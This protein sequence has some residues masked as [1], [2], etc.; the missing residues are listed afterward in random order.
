LQTRRLAFSPDRRHIL[1][2]TNRIKGLKGLL[3]VVRGNNDK[4]TKIISLCAIDRIQSGSNS[5]RFVLARSDALVEGSAEVVAL[6]E[7][8]AACIS[9]VYRDPH[10]EDLTSLETLDLVVPNAA[11]YEVLLTVLENLQALYLEEQQRQTANIQLL[12]QYWVE[13]DKEWQTDLNL[14]EWLSICDKMQ[15][16]L[17]RMGLIQMFKEECTRHGR[18]EQGLLTFAAAAKM[19]EDVRTR[20]VRPD[21]SPFE[22][23]WSVLVQTDPIPV[24]TPGLDNAGS[25]STVAF[26]SFLRSQQ[27]EYSTTLEEA[28]DLVHIL[29]QQ[30]T[31][32]DLLAGK[33]RPKSQNSERL[34]KRRFLSFLTSDANDLLHPM[35]G[36][37]GSDDMTH[38]LSHYW[39]NTSHDTYLSAI[40]PSF[41]KSAYARIKGGHTLSNEQ[42]YTAALLRG[43]RCLEIDLWDSFNGLEPIIARHR[44]TH[45]TDKVTSLD[46]VLRSIRHFLKQQPYAYP[47]I[48]K[49]E[50]HCSKAVQ[51]RVAMS[52]HDY[53]GSDNLIASAL[54]DKLDASIELPSPE[55]I[56]GKVVIIGKRPTIIG[57]GGMVPKDDYDDDI[58]VLSSEEPQEAAISNDDCVIVGFN[59]EGPIRSADPNEYACSPSNLS[60]TALEEAGLADRALTNA[61]E[62]YNVLLLQSEVLEK[63][64]AHLTHRSGLTPVE[65]KERAA[66]VAKGNDGGISHDFVFN[67]EEKSSKDEGIE[68]HEVL[69]EFLAGS[70]STYESA[71]AE[72][73]VAAGH[74]AQL[75]MILRDKEEAYT[76]AKANFDM[77]RQREMAVQENAKR[78]ANEARSNHEHAESAKLRAEKVRELLA[79]RKDQ[80]S[81]F[82]NVVQT[83]TTEANISEKRAADAQA[84]AKRASQ[85]AERDRSKADEETKKE[86]NLE[87]EVNELHQQCLKATEGA[88]Q[89]RE[90]VEKA[91][92]MLDRVNDQIKLLERSSQFR[93]ESQ[94]VKETSVSNK[95]VGSFLEKHEIKLS[96]RDK[97]RRLIKEASEENSA[98]EMHRNRLQQAFEEK[99]YHWK[100][101]ADLAAQARKAA[102]R[103]SHVAEELAEDAEEEREA[104]NLRHIARE[105]AEATV[106]NKDSYLTSLEA[107]LV[108]AERAAAEAEMAAVLSRRKAEHLEKEA[109]KV[110]D[111]AAFKRIVDDANSEWKLARDQYEVARIT[112]EK[113]DSALAEEK[114]RLDTNSEVYRNVAAEVAAESDRMKLEHV[115]Q[116]EAIVAYNQAVVARQ[117]AVLAYESLGEA[118]AKA[119]TKRLAARRALE[120]KKKMESMVEIPVDLARM[121]MLHSKKYNNWRSSLELS[122]A[123]MH[124]MAHNVLLLKVQNDLEKDKTDILTFTTNHLLRVFPSWKE[125]QQKP[126]SNYDP[127][128]AWRLGCQLVSTNFHSADESLLIS[129]GR[130]RQNGSCGYVLKPAYLIDNTAE[131]EFEQK[132]TFTVLGGCNLP[133]SIRKCAGPISPLVKVSLYSGSASE[134]RVSYRTRPYIHNGLNPVWTSHNKFSF[135]IPIPSVSMISFSVWHASD[136]GGEIFVAAAAVPAACI[137]EGYRNVALFDANHSRNGPYASAGLLIRAS[138]K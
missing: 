35:H 22:M 28:A 89:A 37:T 130:F 128:F 74:E 82:G 114:R 69:P 30:A 96:E 68:L 110:K 72:A 55:Q 87:Q 51:I 125:I 32:E 6:L 41:G 78:S 93:R 27:K 20:S 25:I 103:S 26:L 40:L 76:M 42:T 53:L 97:C 77:S 34:S 39:I 5:K 100:M 24:D 134:M 116:Q 137:R 104:A 118:T 57:P 85:A 44:P 132:W 119:E 121:T 12:N 60:S 11:D 15:V 88:K 70:Q 79:N 8:D 136:E 23:L 36:K 2:T 131:T 107:Q 18:E 31:A 108:E 61:E 71:A 123:Y 115:Y 47:I 58:D 113:K 109:E 56:R 117:Q 63:R 19:L 81:S 98:A 29:N 14:N 46:I 21:S 64:A 126:C 67:N 83:A 99:S 65:V 4:G 124:S 48:L 129:E 111:L 3:K 106:E 75:H 9:I 112:R 84:R 66:R 102:D 138:R 33:S 13:L 45:Q 50:N 80:S 86:E 52:L 135:S 17:K 7:S 38:P 120:Y 90:R 91:A 92:A 101:Q 16:G 73:S 10:R 49:I 59:S 43:V 127:V 54:D 105:R 95:A 94:A 1:V 133:K 122:N 62:R